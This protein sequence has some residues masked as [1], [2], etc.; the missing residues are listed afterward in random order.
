MFDFFHGS[1]YQYMMF[2]QPI[3][4]ITCLFFVWLIM[5]APV[6]SMTIQEE[7]K[8][9]EVFS[10]QVCSHFPLIHDQDIIEY[11]RYVGERL[12][13]NVP[14]KHFKFHFYVIREKSYNAFAGPGGHIFVHS[15]LIEAMESELELAGILSHEIAHVICRHISERMEQTKPVSIAALAATIAGAFIGGSV[16]A[17]VMAGSAAAQQS[18]FLAYTREN[19]READQ[20]SLR[21]LRDS[22]YNG[23]GLL[24]ILQKI[25]KYSWVEV[26][27]IPGYMMTHPAVTER[28]AYI[29]TALNA[30][31]EFDRSP[32]DLRSYDFKKIQIRLCAI[33]SDIYPTQL[34]KKNLKENPDDF[35]NHYGYGL[36]LMV[37]GKRKNAL[38][39]LTKALQIRPFDS[40]ILRDIGIAHLHLGDYDQAIKYLTSASNIVSNDI[41]CQFHIGLAREKMGY[42][43]AA[44]R[45][46]E[47]LLISY[48][49]MNKL[50]YYLGNLYGKKGQTCDAH[51]HLGSYYF[52]K[53]QLK[54]ARYHL[55]K[56][57]KATEK[58]TSR[59]KEIEQM[60]K[61]MRKNADHGRSRQ[62]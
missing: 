50:H 26:S 33:Y 62:K 28:L 54:Q 2:N 22:G 14:D 38:T 17:A 3:K 1:V 43:D 13:K 44:A 21:Y 9:G 7:I 41:D 52:Q 39:E 49:D 57:K 23:R 40:S 53:N 60:L 18:V 36:R 15:G 51:Y 27:G 56:A 58:S 45:L 31:P 4:Q 25:R 16:G 59:Y 35:L 61:Q 42:L 46:W 55:K 19:E 37:S 30:K 5:S 10:K 24:S 34:F 29:D 6:G 11:V 12:L 20:N 47:R 48:P 8:L 32:I